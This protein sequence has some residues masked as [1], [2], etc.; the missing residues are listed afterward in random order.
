MVRVLLD[1]NVVSVRR[2]GTHDYEIVRRIAHWA[3]AD[4]YISSVT[5]A[6]I[7]YGANLL[8]VGRRRLAIEEWLEDLEHE[9]EDRILSVDTHVGRIFGRIMAATK[10]QGLTIQITDG[11]IASTA[12]HHGLSVVTRNVKHFEPTGVLIINPW[13][14]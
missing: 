10:Q 4:S 3:A 2:D 12:I 6:E 8:P 9:F 7:A 14:S 13:D 5:I 1:T 11:F